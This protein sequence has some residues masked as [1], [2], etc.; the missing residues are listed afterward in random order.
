MNLTK[1][2]DRSKALLGLEK[3][4]GRTFQTEARYGILSI[5]FERLL[6]WQRDQPL[7]MDDITYPEG[8][9]APT[10]SWMSFMGKINYLDVPFGKVNWTGDIANPF[11]TYYGREDLPWDGGLQATAHQL[12]IGEESLKSRVQT[13]LTYVKVDPKE[14]KGVVI[15]TGR[16]TNE[17]R[18]TDQYV[19]LI[20]QESLG[21]YKRIGVGTLLDIHISPETE[22][23]YII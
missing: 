10:W 6:L 11:S 22:L 9:G 15:G 2:T 21:I 7:P 5:Y 19:L 3:R 20:Q 1:T 13:D 12:S 18:T 17:S 8:Q 23:V 16:F 14:F 4:L